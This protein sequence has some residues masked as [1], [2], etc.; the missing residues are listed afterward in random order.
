MPLRRTTCIKT[1]TLNAPL[2]VLLPAQDVHVKTKV[3]YWT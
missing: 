3:A 1:L 2:P